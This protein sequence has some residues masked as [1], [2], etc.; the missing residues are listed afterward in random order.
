MRDIR[1]ALRSLFANRGFT[2]AAVTT[3]AFGIGL[4]TAAFSVVNAMLIKQL[5]VPHA[6]ELVM[7]YWLRQPEP[8]VASYSGY[9]RQGPNGGIR[10]SFSYLTFERFR[11]HSQT[12]GNVFAI[13][14]VRDLTVTADGQAEAASG[15]LVSGAYFE[16]LGVRAARGRLLTNDDDRIGAD[17]VVVISHRYWQRRFQEAPS[18]VGRVIDVNRAPAVV[19]GVTAP[20]FD[21]TRIGEPTDVT[22]PMSLAARIE[23]GAARPVSTWWV[24]IMARLKSGVAHSQALADVDRL[25]V[26]SMRESWLARPATTISKGTSIPQLGIMD[27]SR[28]PEGPR[29]DAMPVLAGVLGIAGVVLLIGC[30]NVGNLVLART[31][32]R[33]QD[34][35]I[36]LALG[37]GRWRV[38]RELLTENLIVAIAGGVGGILV[39]FWGRNFLGWLPGGSAPIIDPEIDGRVILF[40][41]GL[42]L[43]TAILC[44]LGPALR[45]TRTTL[46]ASI[47]AARSPRRGLLRRVLVVTQV[48]LSLALLVVAG[49]FVQTLRNLGR[50]DVGFDTANL[51]VF[52]VNPRSQDGNAARAFASLENVRSA[53]ETIPGVRSATMSALPVLAQAEWTAMVATDTGA[54][55]RSAFIQTIGPRFFETLGMPLIAG[56]DLSAQDRDGAPRVAVINETMAKQ[57]FAE[58]QPIGRHF[59]FTEGADRGTQVEV[60]GIVRDAAYATLREERR[61]TLYLPHRQVSPGTMT[62]EVKTAVDPLSIVPSVQEAVRRVEPGLSL[63]GITSQEQQIRQTIA[64]PNTF[65]V[66]TSGFGAVAL[67]LA[68]LGVYG[69]VSFDVS[70]RTREIGIRMALGAKRGDVVRAVLGEMAGI[71]AIGGGLGWALGVGA[72]SLARGAMFGVQPGNPIAIAA[73]TIVLAIAATAAGYLPARRATSVDPTHALRHD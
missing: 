5:P 67:T 24:Q 28:G 70:R 49:Q 2:F 45:A 4:N 17:P 40:A 25:F 65:A 44:G 19:V 9:G 34:V 30:V 71:V 52:R 63:S 14:R 43:L 58:P 33:Q 41:S 46:S 8:T 6:D 56:R 73:A 31:M 48:A 21:G 60:V 15:D 54:P 18:I 26:E 35:A 29:R 53:I 7:F 1:Y 13:S 68:C 42:S 55:A 20:G 62:F 66:V 57:L 37:G 38:I 10:T 36:R 47:N 39:A 16:T 11:D 22:I 23:G 64:L 51:L 69:L 61:P 27:G 32:T 50:V 59:Q 12:L 72:S 3:L